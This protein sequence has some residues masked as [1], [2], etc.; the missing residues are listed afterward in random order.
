M[1]GQ[2]E[3]PDVPVEQEP[4]RQNENRSE[5]KTPVTPPDR[6]GDSEDPAMELPGKPG[7]PKVVDQMAHADDSDAGNENAETVVGFDDAG[8]VGRSRGEDDP[9]V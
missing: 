1:Q 4:V 6:E 2:K 8:S 5:E 3:K 9:R 7:S